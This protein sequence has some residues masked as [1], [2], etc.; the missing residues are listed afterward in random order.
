MTLERLASS[1]AF[2][3]T[4]GFYEHASRATRHA[5]AL[6]RLPAAAGRAPARCPAL[7]W[8]SGLTC[9]EETFIDQGGRAA[10]RR[11]ARPRARRARHEP[12]RARACPAT[13]TRGTSARA[14]A[15]TSTPPRRR[16]RAHYRMYTYVDRRAAGARR[17]RASPSTP[18]R[19]AIFGH[20]MGG[21]GALV[22]GAAQ[23][24]PLPVVSAFAP[25]ARRRARA[26]GR[27]GASPAISAP[28][29]P[30]GATTTRRALIEDRGWAGPPLLVD[31][32]TAR[33][34]PRHAAASPS[35]SRPRARRPA[36]R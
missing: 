9:T 30:P 18:T 25:I 26:V 2:G 3:G 23:S 16:G 10:R 31:Q 1:R 6:R 15:S 13:T 24:R 5:D 32:G 8:L 19:A 36:C 7:Y 4:Q 14:P 34:V 22:I 29:A 20:S 27:E 28:T 12:A 11:R 35:C 17:A 21:H 33:Q